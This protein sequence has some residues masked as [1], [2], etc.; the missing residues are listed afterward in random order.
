ME[1]QHGECKSAR[2][3]H[4]HVLRKNPNTLLPNN[5]IP[6]TKGP[7]AAT[8]PCPPSGDKAISSLLQLE[9][10]ASWSLMTGA[11]YHPVPPI[12][13]RQP[14]QEKLELDYFPKN[15]SLLENYL[16]AALLRGTSSHCQSSTETLILNVQSKGMNIRAFIIKARVSDL[17]N[18]ARCQY[19][20]GP[21]SL[22]LHKGP[23]KNEEPHD[24]IK[25]V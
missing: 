6:G 17:L 1:W 21:S 3:I 2:D 11:G 22:L 20:K 13:W 15:V 7:K 8:L 4:I 25:S 23:H 18:P 19:I 14:L 9:P 24:Q 5:H 16:D 12:S 10:P